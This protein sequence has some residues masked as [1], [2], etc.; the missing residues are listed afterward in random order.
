VTRGSA[1]SSEQ[2][3]H[4]N[5]YLAAG[6]LRADATRNILLPAFNAM[7]RRTVHILSDDPEFDRVFFQNLHAEGFDISY[8]TFTGDVKNFKSILQHL[9][10]DLERHERYAIV[11]FGEAA[12]HTLSVFQEYLFP[13]C[14]SL[15]CYYPTAI[16]SPTHK[17]P[18][19]LDLLCHLASVQ[20]FGAASF[21][22]YVY[23]DT[24]PGFAESDLEEFDRFAAGLSWGRTL[25]CLRRGF[26]MV[27]DLE[28]V[29]DEYI[30][31]KTDFPFI[32]LRELLNIRVQTNMKQQQPTLYRARSPTL[33]TYPP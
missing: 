4:F 16:P 18:A 33:I 29:V 1:S 3:G 23:P 8:E 9:E 17:Y 31:C 2:K 15:I 12:T 32:W 14:V 28:E 24:C 19:S 21:K 22:T 11:A 26:G 25:A 13:Q 7:S 30:K 10:D 20:P 5:G 27:V 6:T